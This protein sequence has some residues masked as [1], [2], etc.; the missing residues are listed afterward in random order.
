MVN[1]AGQQHICRCGSESGIR[2]GRGSPA[3]S[4]SGILVV[5]APSVVP[6][7][8]YFTEVA[9][10]QLLPTLAAGRTDSAVL[11]EPGATAA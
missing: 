11:G 6:G 5:P 10:P 7:S 9:P 8:R 2:S 3:I 4:A 1:G